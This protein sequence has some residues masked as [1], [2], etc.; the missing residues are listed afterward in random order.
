MVCAEF[1][2]SVCRAE[3]QPVE[4]D[5]RVRSG[6]HAPGMGVH[7]GRQALQERQHPYQDQGFALSHHG[8][9]SNRKTIRSQCFPVL[10]KPPWPRALSTNSS[11]TLN[12]TCITGTTTS[13]AMRS[14][15]LSRKEVC[16]RFQHETK[17]CP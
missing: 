4:M 14:M 12:P 17:I 11:T 6:V 7:Q 3:M 5:V 1:R 15:G 2:F 8:L 9:D 10:P 16:P 13:C